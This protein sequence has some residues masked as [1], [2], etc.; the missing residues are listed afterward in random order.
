MPAQIGDR[1]K[2]II[3]QW[4]EGR[5]EISKVWLLA[6]C[7]RGPVSAGLFCCPPSHVVEGSSTATRL[8]RESLPRNVGARLHNWVGGQFG[9][10]L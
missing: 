10:I 9:G 8:C 2:S 4:A 7:K 6:V 5:G 3:S 1:E